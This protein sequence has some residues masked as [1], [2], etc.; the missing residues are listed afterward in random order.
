MA[1]SSKIVSEFN[2]HISSRN[3]AELSTLIADDH[4]FIDTAGNRVVGRTDVVKA[5]QSFFEA[6]PDYYNEFKTMI[7]RGSEVVVEGQSYC[8]DSRLSG[9]ALW[10][11]ELKD[12][13]LIKWRVY[14][15]NSENRAS[16]GMLGSIT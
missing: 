5:W 8:S 12:S 16:L 9:P 3:L 15:D 2:S 1:N 7:E 10:R 11:A 14:E 4:V 13:K 6:F